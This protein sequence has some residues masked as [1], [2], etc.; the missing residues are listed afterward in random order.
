MPAKPTNRMKFQMWTP[1]FTIK[2]EGSL[3]GGVV[4][5]FE[6]LTIEQKEVALK[7]M[8]EHL[9]KAKAKAEG[10]SVVDVPVSKMSLEDLEGN[11]LD[12]TS[13]VTIEIPPSKG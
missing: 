13:V 10:L 1:D 3:V 5:A 6:F 4:H 9:I 7:K 2:S 12:R 11:L 8:T